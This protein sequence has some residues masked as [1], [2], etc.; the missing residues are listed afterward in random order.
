MA[1]PVKTAINQ[2]GSE[3]TNF[4]NLNTSLDLKTENA[5]TPPKVDT[6]D[7][8]LAKSVCVRNV[9]YS[10]TVEEL[11]DHFK[12]CCGDKGVAGIKRVTICCDKNSGHPLG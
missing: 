11:K 7:D 5:K 4:T 8:V 12:V 9:E 6:E 3:T 1:S 2:D 10:T